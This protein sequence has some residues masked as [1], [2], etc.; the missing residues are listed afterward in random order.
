MDYTNF[1]NEMYSQLDMIKSKII[2]IETTIGDINSI[3]DNING[4]VI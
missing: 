3:L 4:E 1:S 2:D